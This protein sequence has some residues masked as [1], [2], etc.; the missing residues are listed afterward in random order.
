MAKFEVLKKSQIFLNF[1]G[2]YLDDSSKPTHGFLAFL[3]GY[4]IFISQFIGLIASAAFILK[5]PTDIKAC[6]G[7]LK[8][9]VAVTQ[10]AGMFMGIKN[11]TMKTK[12]LQ[13]E[14]QDIVNEGISIS[15]II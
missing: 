4:Y 12:A 11:N 8:V 10:C 15:V 2:I 3:A 7:A 9:C 6:L 1:V 13:D 5:Y 14:F